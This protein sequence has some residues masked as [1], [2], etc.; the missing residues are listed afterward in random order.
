MNAAELIMSIHQQWWRVP[1]PEQNA[2]VQALLKKTPEQF[3]NVPGIDTHALLMYL[4]PLAS[5]ETLQHVHGKLLVTARL[6]SLTDRRMQLLRYYAQHQIYIT[7]DQRDLLA[8]VVAH[9]V[10]LTEAFHAPAQRIISAGIFNGAD[11]E[12]F[13]F[14]YDLLNETL[15]INA[16]AAK[17]GPK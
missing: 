11:T 15:R 10:P 4:L 16:A 1:E 9:M 17:G 12:A 5:L 14:F 7:H 13:Q 8:G 6:M 3:I 2:I